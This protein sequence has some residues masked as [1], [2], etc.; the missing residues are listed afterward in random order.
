METKKSIKYRI[1]VEENLN[2]TYFNF[3]IIS[4]SLILILRSEAYKGSFNL[5]FTAASS[6]LESRLTF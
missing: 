5:V 1:A 4:I 6:L 2:I 3:R